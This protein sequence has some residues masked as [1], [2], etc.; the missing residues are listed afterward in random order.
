M[1]SS[2]G[3]SGDVGRKVGRGNAAS[4]RL[5]SRRICWR[6]QEWLARIYTHSDATSALLVHMGEIA[7]SSRHQ[8]RISNFTGRKLR[9]YEMD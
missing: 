4:I 5:D 9:Q 3:S 7:S 1:G 2:V 6:R 8:F